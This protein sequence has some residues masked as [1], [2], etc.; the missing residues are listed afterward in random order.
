MYYISMD[1]Y[2]I[3]RHFLALGSSLNKL[4]HSG[5]D[6]ENVRKVHIFA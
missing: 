5:P 6:S 1:R 3:C 4:P 2:S